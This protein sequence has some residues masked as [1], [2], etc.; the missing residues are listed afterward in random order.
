MIQITI[1]DLD[2]GDEATLKF[3]KF[4]SEQRRGMNGV[5]E[6]GIL[7]DFELNGSEVCLIKL[8]SGCESFETHNP[9]DAG[10]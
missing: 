6:N 7:R 3:E 4:T 8:W 5:C 1:K 10:A 9:G 2:T